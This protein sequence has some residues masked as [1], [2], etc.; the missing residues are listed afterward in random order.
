ME[1]FDPELYVASDETDLLDAIEHDPDVLYEDGG[2][3]DGEIEVIQVPGHTP[4][5]SALLLR[6]EN[7]LLSSDVLDG[8]DRR[9]LPAGYLLPPPETFNWDH[10]AA[11]S[12]LDRLLDYEFDAV[13]VFHG[14]HVTDDPKAKLEKYLNFKE[15]YRQ[16]LL[17]GQGESIGRFER[18]PRLAAVHGHYVH[19]A[20]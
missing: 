19:R 2:V 10:A 16:S 17:E 18:E 11:E 20:K 7:V 9:G 8:A 12:N 1:P 4:A 3:L 14:S 15:H 6:D 5:P 13:F